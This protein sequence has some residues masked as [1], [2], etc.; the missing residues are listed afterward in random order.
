[1]KVLMV[2]LLW[3]RPSSKNKNNKLKNVNYHCSTICE[4]WGGLPRNQS[5]IQKFIIG[6]FLSTS[7]PLM[8]VLI[9]SQKSCKHL[10]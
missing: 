1:M 7:N 10:K 6:P 2:L 4:Y 9:S 3:K 5:N 8:L